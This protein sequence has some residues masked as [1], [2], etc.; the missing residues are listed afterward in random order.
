M[1]Q[2][3]QR[4][5]NP[6]PALEVARAQWAAAAEGWDAQS[7]TLRAWLSRPTQT[8]L[9]MA[10]IVPG[11][12]VLDVAAGAG[13]QTMALAQRVGP[14]G[15]IVATD[16][17]PALVERLRRHVSGAGYQML[18]ARAVDAQERLPE[19]D[20]F[21]AAICRLG[22]MLMPEPARCLAAI[23]A[24]LKPGGRLS[25][26]VFAGPA[27]NPCIGTV[28][29]TVLRHAGVGPRDP[30]TP[31]GLLSLGRPGHLDQLF[32][33]AGFSEVSSFRIEAP[34]RLPSVDDYIEFLRTAAA[35]VMAM[36]SQLAPPAREAAWSDL[37]ERL[38]QF[39]TPDG[40]T[41][42]NTL[43]LTTGRKD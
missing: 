25:T 27:E 4:E 29:A 3:T 35:P 6:H 17:S 34:F 2:Q 8:M 19:V 16:L 21:D 32:V 43:L 5:V 24:A 41:G 30:F 42:P 18:E 26:M 23:H 12:C 28:M 38:A 10:A 20:V 36:L 22:L 7:P 13:G 37:R 11:H 9:E 39:Q 31:G 40:W 14:Q 15:R 1:T 33:A